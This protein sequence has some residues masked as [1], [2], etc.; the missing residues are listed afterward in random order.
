MH[1]LYV[2]EGVEMWRDAEKERGEEEQR[3]EGETRM[4]REEG[5]KE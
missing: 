2:V 1:I 3:R 4:E 5:W